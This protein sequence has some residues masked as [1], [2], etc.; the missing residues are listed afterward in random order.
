MCENR[1]DDVKGS[2][3][4]TLAVINR[5]YHTGVCV[6][7]Q[8][9]TCMRFHHYPAFE[10]PVG[11]LNKMKM[12]HISFKEIFLNLYKNPVEFYFYSRFWY[13]HQIHSAFAL[14]LVSR[15]GEQ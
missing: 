12:K 14:L 5:I 7:T 6:Y 1:T 9:E 2:Y 3:K 4:G 13:G 15:I 11:L 10:V 8:N